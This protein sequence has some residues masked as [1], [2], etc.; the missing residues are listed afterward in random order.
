MYRLARRSLIAARAI[1][2]GTTI[3]ADMLTIKRPGYGIKPVHLELV[4]GRVAR[5]DID[6][7]DV[8]TWDMV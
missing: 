7:D 8:I 3:T 5:R 2:S 1:P 4:V 6:E